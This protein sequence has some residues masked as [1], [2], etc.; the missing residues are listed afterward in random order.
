MIH[1]SSYSLRIMEGG[2]WVAQLV[3]HPTL[4]FGS[5]HDL[6]VRDFESCMDSCLQLGS[7][8]GFSLSAHALLVVSL[9]INK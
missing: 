2:T 1:V 6:L 4:Y 5:V 3:G 8:L 9:K 7:C